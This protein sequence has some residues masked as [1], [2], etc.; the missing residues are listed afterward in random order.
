MTD[1]EADERLW[2]A[3]VVDAYGPEDVSWDEYLRRTSRAD[4][5]RAVTN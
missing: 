3:F 5:G 1:D 4:D 2:R